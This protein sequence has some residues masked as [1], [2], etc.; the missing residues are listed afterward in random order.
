MSLMQHGIITARKIVIV[1]KINVVVV[2]VLLNVI[3]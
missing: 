2:S 3:R 1:D